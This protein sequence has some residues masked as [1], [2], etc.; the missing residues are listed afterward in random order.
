MKDK[1]VKFNHTANYYRLRN[2]AFA[3]ILC[4]SA[5]VIVAVP[6]YV[7]LHNESSIHTEIM[8]VAETLGTDGINLDSIE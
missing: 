4:I 7:S 8:D 5:A 3:L 6:T 2:T 1:L